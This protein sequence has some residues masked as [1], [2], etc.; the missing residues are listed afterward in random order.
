MI[1]GTPSRLPGARVA[2]GALAS[3]I[4]LAATTARAQNAVLQ[5]GKTID[6][7]YDGGDV[8]E[9]DAA[10][11][12][13]IFAPKQVLAQKDQPVPLLVF[14]HGTNKKKEPFRFIGGKVEEPDLRLMLGDLMEQG[15]LP[16]MVI[17]A[18]TTVV[19]SVVPQSMWPDFDLDRLVE[20]TLARLR[21]RATI[22]LDR[23]VLA[24]HSGGAC[25]PQGGLFSALRGT[26]LPLR[27]VFAIDTCMEVDD[28]V[29]LALAPPGTDVFVSYQVVGWTRAFDDFRATFDDAARAR[30]GA[31]RV[32]EEL[33]P[34][35]PHPHNA[36]VE[37]VFRSHLAAVVR[38][39]L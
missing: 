18:P 20:A 6:F 39:P 29:P 2:R 33:H 7:A 25:N 38:K 1:G 10:Y 17:V 16:P 30:P 23:V 22:D 21:G 24:G 9:G 27:A 12:A 15:E 34:D 35:S 36:M 14:L 19:M 32:V 26:S 28:A 4:V 11:T 37:A 31:T 13:R 8:R 5:G 3:A